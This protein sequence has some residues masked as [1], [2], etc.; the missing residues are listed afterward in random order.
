MKTIEITAYSFS[1]LS[2]NAKMRALTD[3]QS[4]CEYSWS[5]DAIKSLGAFMDAVG[6]TM[7]NY[8]IDWL[9]PSRS[10]VRYDGNPHGQFIKEDLTGA[11][12]DYS[13]TTTWNKTRSIEGAINEFLSEICNDYEYQLS[14]DGFIEYCDGNE[15][16]FDENGNQLLY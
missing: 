3:Y 11:F 7:T 13:L 6:V 15:I 10:K 1:E 12:S 2:D 8:D 14:E 5:Y 16:I 4:D 9:C